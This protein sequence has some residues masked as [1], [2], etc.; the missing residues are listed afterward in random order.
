MIV[1]Q[2][3][4]QFFIQR[5]ADTQ[6]G[7]AAAAGINAPDCA[8]DIAGHVINETRATED[9]NRI[10]REEEAQ[11]RLNNVKAGP[12]GQFGLDPRHRICRHVKRT[13]AGGALESCEPNEIWLIRPSFVDLEPN[14]CFDVSETRPVGGRDGISLRWDE[15]GSLRNRVLPIQIGHSHRDFQSVRY[16]VTPY[17][18]C[19]INV[20]THP[21]DINE[22]DRDGRDDG[23]PRQRDLVTT[24]VSIL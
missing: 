15:E 12:R 4:R 21:L 8:A 14:G 13:S 11:A 20:S 6:I 10:G 3:Q 19:S 16:P 17:Q 18:S 23:K 1:R 7:I 5:H 24:E 22:P 9:D 2:H